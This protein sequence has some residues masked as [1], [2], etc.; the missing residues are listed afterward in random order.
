MYIRVWIILKNRDIWLKYLVDGLKSK[1]FF[2]FK[3]KY[4]LIFK[5]E[6]VNFINIILIWLM[7]KDNFYKVIGK[8]KSY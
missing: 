8:L 5:K 2:L 7:K 3:V 6:G 4:F 1:S